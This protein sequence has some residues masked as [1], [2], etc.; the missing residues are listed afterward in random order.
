MRPPL[1][2]ELWFSDDELTSRLTFRQWNGKERS[3][4]FEKDEFYCSL[5]TMVQKETGG[6]SVITGHKVTKLDPSSQQVTLDSGQVLSYG[7]CLLATGGEPKRHPAFEAKMDSLP[8]DRIIYFRRA[9]DFHRVYKALNDPKT[10][11]ITIIGGGFL[12]SELS[13]SLGARSKLLF[14]R[15]ENPR[16]VTIHQIISEKGNLGQVVPEYLSEYTTSKV[17]RE[18]TNVL[19]SSDIV[20]VEAASSDQIKLK[21]TEGQEI[22]TDYVIISIGLEPNLQLAQEA[23]LEV[24]KD[25]NG[26]LVN[27]ELQ[28]RNNLWVAGDASCYYDVKLGRRRVEHHDH[29]IM[30]GRLAGHNMSSDKHK[31][32]KHQSMFWSDLGQEIGFEAV[33]LID[34]KLPTVGIFTTPEEPS[35]VEDQVPASDAPKE[36]EPDPYRRGIIFYLNPDDK[37]VVGILLWNLFNRLSI[38]RRIINESKSFDDLSQLAKHFSIYSKDDYE[39]DEDDLKDLEKKEN[40]VKKDE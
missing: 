23:N 18:G 4:Y 26:Y 8:N 15:P 32:Y 35:V 25:L 11:S 34:S 30:S 36:A 3:L 12:G 21:L 39:D 13:C 20:S 28:A 16:E 17:K 14:Y 5:Q 7:K 33:G 2:K 9:D 10:K 19:T 37:K 6:V 22:T 29:A 27:S 1:T 40:D 31:I 38:A 24:H